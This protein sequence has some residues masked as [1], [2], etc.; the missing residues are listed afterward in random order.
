MIT[1]FFRFFFFRFFCLVGEGREDPNSLK[2]S[3]LQPFKWCF[4]GQMMAQ[5]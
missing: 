2:A 3:H 1:F 4:C 5:L